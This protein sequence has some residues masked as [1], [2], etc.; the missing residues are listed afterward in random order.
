MNSSNNVMKKNKKLYISMILNVVEGLMSG[1]NFA[2]LYFLI[3]S[4]VGKTLSRELVMNYSTLLIGI[5]VLR[6]I[7]YTIAYT[8]GHIA[9]AEMSQKIRLFL[10]DKI[11]KIPLS[12]FTKVKTGEYINVVTSDVSNYENILTHKLGDIIK[13]ISL[14]SML[15]IFMGSVYFKGGLIIFVATLI[16]FPALYLSARVVKK[17]GT[18]KNNTISENVS[19]VVEYIT[20]IQTFRAYGLGGTKN[21]T[22]TKSMKKYSDISYKYE[23]KIIPI[24]SV[25][26]VITGLCMPAIILVGQSSILNGTLNVIDFIMEIMIPTFACKLITAIF[27]DFTSYKNMMIS[28]RAIERV[29]DEEEEEISSI[30]FEPKTHEINFDNVCFSYEENE[31]ILKNVSFKAENEKLTAI[32]GE[33]GSG[34]STILNLIVKYY[35]PQS[36]QIKIG[37]TVINNI[38]S[39]KV[40][41]YISIVDQD[42]FLFNDSIKNN[43]RHARQ[44]ATDAEIIEAC[45]VANCD[46][47]I[48]KMEHGYDTFVGENGN[49]LSG[50]ERQRLSIARAILKNSPILLLDE[51]TASL[52]IENEIAVKYAVLNLLKNK[53]TVIMIAHTLSIIQNADKIIVVSD[54]KIIEQGKH[55][56]LI[57]NSGKYYNMWNAEKELYK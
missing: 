9:G 11:K 7:I 56:E 32:I 34:K 31:K 37:G 21:Q 52:D 40:L 51:A 57:N 25:Q 26:A 38:N 13:N 28:R 47:F 3:K 43:I 5:F 46:S 45:K 12:K 18:E 55:D 23:A 10:G 17:Y 44:N 1:T 6:L 33:S 41:S 30:N 54:G 16:M 14:L 53:K 42:V 8:G 20:G 36:G 35:E 22:V 49:S 39:S 4:L 29:V 2:V 15:T 50:G 24:G 19:N 27:V 48:R